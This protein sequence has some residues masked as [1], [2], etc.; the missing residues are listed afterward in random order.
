MFS[1]QSTSNFL[2]G[3]Y[4]HLHGWVFRLVSGNGYVVVDGEKKLVKTG[5]T[6]SVSKGA[7]HLIHAQTDMNIIEIQIGESISVKDKHIFLETF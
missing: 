3:Y 1:L 7:K 5:D 4:C 2:C 6:I